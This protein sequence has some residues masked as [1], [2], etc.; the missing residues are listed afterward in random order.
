MRNP[1]FVNAMT[2]INFLVCLIWLVAYMVYHIVIIYEIRFA[3]K[4]QALA[5]RL[6]VTNEEKAKF[7]DKH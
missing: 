3:F 1:K 6:C 5:L 7:K 4:M 2:V